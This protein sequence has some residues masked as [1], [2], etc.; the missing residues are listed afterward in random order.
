MALA[1][2]IL[3]LAPAGVGDV[4]GERILEWMMS[5]VLSPHANYSDGWL[6]FL[7]MMWCAFWLACAAFSGLCAAFFWSGLPMDEEAYRRISLHSVTLT[8]A[9][10]IILCC[11][12]VVLWVPFLIYLAVFRYAIKRAVPFWH[13]G[14]PREWIGDFSEH[15]FSHKP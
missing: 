2:W 6:A 4:V 9:P 15:D 1:G 13:S 8:W 7:L 12:W 11:A 5:W 14:R 10:T 3:V